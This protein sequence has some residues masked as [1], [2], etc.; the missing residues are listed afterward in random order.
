MTINKDLYINEFP[1]K[2]R[3]MAYLVDEYI[4]SNIEFDLIEPNA[5]RG[6]GYKRNGKRG[7]FAKLCTGRKCLILRYGSVGDKKGLEIQNKID[8]LL[9]REYSRTETDNNK[10][11]HEAFVNLDWVSEFYQ[12]KSFINEAYILKP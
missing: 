3:A 6:V 1:L 9:G 10:Y 5:K 12:I 2:S 8:N 11:V 7:G 4:N